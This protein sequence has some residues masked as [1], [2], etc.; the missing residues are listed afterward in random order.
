M[1]D[2]CYPL[3]KRTPSGGGILWCGPDANVLRHAI[4]SSIICVKRNFPGR[5]LSNYGVRMAQTSTT[6]WTLS[7]HRAEQDDSLRT[8]HCK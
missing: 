7:N 5:G 2:T 6:S 3:F 8:L 4:H 1:L